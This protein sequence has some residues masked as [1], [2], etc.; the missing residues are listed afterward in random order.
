MGYPPI[1]LYL[2]HNMH[3]NMQ[4]TFTSKQKLR[5]SRKIRKKSLFLDCCGWSRERGGWSQM[6]GWIGWLTRVRIGRLDTSRPHGPMAPPPR[7]H[8]LTPS[9]TPPTPPHL[10]P[11]PQGLPRTLLLLL[12]HLS[13]PP[14]GLPRTL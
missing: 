12:P 1:I 6:D 2:H 7:S 3:H 10:S 13:P 8:L 11:P 14:Q 5:F 4:K 9:F